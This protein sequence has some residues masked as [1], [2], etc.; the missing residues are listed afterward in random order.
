MSTHRLIS[1]MREG[2]GRSVLAML[3]GLLLILQLALPAVA[4]A[5]SSQQPAT[6]AFNQQGVLDLAGVSV[7]RLV[8]SYKVPQPSHGINKP[9]TSCTALGTLIGSWLPRVSPPSTTTIDQNT[10][11]LTDG[12]VVNPTGGSC[13]PGGTLVAIEIFANTSYT[14][15]SAS[16]LLAQLACDG[17]VCHDG[18][19][20]KGPQEVVSSA[21][22]GGALVSFHGDVQQLQP[23]LTA[24]PSGGTQLGI[25]LANLNGTWP[26]AP[27]VS[28]TIIPP[29][30]LTP[31][32]NPLTSNNTPGSSSA[33]A[34][35]V[36]TLPTTIGS[37]GAT[38]AGEPG[39]P[40]VNSEGALVGMRLSGG[41]TLSAQQ[42]L[43]LEGQ[44]L[45]FSPA[46]VATHRNPL[47]AGWV[48]GIT[49]YESGDYTH[50]AQTLQ[51]IARLNPLFQAPAFFVQQAMAK[52][53]ATHTPPSNTPQSGAP[54]GMNTWLLIIGLIAGLLV[55][56]LLLV[57]VSLTFGRAR[58]RRREELA[59]FKE[60]E[61]A[62]QRE[63]EKE[64]QRQQQLQKARATANLQAPSPVPEM[65]CPH[66]KHPVMAA[67]T[68]CPYCRYPLSPS[69][70]GVYAGEIVQQSS[71]IAPQMPPQAPSQ[72]A[73]QPVPQ[74]QQADYLQ[75]P[76]PVP[77]AAAPAPSISDLPTVEYPPRNGNAALDSAKTLPYGVQQ[78][79]GHN[80]G[81]VV[82]YETDPG[83]KRKHKPNED[84]MLALQGMTSD[85][86]P[87]P[88]GLFVVA[89]GMG[90]H[91]NGQDASR[92][93]IQTLIDYVLPKI[94]GSSQMDDNAYLN[95]LREGVQQANQ[96]VHQ[97][98]MEERA[99]MGTTMT[100]ALVVGATAYVTNVGDSR[101]YLYREPGGLEKITQD[102]SVVASLV[103]AGIIK[104]DD[105]Y[106]HPKRNQ[107]YR[108]LGEKPVV[109]VD[110]FK[111]PLQMGD[112]LLLCSDGLWDM[113]RDPDIQR[114]LSAPMPPSQ[115]GKDL[116]QAAL[117]GGGE[118][119]VTVIVVS[120]TEASGQPQISGIQLL[121]KPDTVSV[122]EL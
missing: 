108:S 24:V 120:I 65:L 97:R 20:G 121:A 93:A 70:S 103:E 47:N 11:L 74:P 114:V 33:T 45:E 99:D 69:D 89:D 72:P 82:G 61:A 12:A 2:R 86:Q 79:Q 91:A 118:D 112:K 38:V 8:V 104:P 117:N 111:V 19:D 53:R 3:G 23:F 59:R 58:V 102:H 77:V 21:I 35:P 56:I 101:T 28:S 64:V 25:E 92:L 10:W 106:T 42:I 83:I 109:E 4:F 115:T 27:A 17:N 94:K 46:Q 13:A 32:P 37:P 68:Y 26:P 51:G 54:A 7:V 9:S 107:I 29:S 49:Q 122:P 55:L 100:A 36:A 43:A 66:C 75:P 105:I 81:M 50:A 40:I 80:L 62:A 5:S 116:I 95:L 90:G 87:R 31:V 30:Y 71:A 18:A 15:Q 119:N 84:S 88:F 113:V 63:A 78:L 98:N 34:T 57:L 52:L 1:R 16:P 39:M 41:G 73:S 85:V 60:E 6:P 14:R 110:A 48:L 22:T 67:D 76:P 96:A 44:Q